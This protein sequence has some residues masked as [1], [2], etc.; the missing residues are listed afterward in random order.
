MAI[1]P[2]LIS[3]AVD[4]V[5]LHAHGVLALIARMPGEAM[6]LAL[7]ASHLREAHQ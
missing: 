5:A 1:I 6:R 4:L 2:H 3:F 7:L